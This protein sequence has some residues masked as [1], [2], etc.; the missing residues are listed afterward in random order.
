MQIHPA[1]SLHSSVLVDVCNK[2]KMSP[3]NSGFRAV[4]IQLIWLRFHQQVA[5]PGASQRSAVSDKFTLTVNWEAKDGS[6]GNNTNTHLRAAQYIGK[7][8]LSW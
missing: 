4:N 8:L 7:I 2:N 5:V 3:D 6:A 1:L